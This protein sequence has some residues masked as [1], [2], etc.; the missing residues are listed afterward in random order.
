MSKAL[1]IVYASA[2]ADEVPILTLEILHPAFAGGAIRTCNG[3]ED[4]ACTLETGDTMTFEASGLDVSLPKRNATG[5]QELNF[6]IENVSGRA[7]RAIRDALEAGGQIDVIYRT[8]L[9]SDLSAPAEPPLK[10]ALVSPS[11]EGATTQVTASYMDMINYAWPRE[12]YT[13][14]FAPGLKYI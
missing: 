3:F 2:P 11:F 14:S 9:A 7:E 4:Q 8:F 6:A 13:I 10:M 1:E 5:R 12:R